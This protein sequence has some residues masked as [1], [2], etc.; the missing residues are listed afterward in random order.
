[1]SEFEYLRYV[2]FGQYLPT[3]STI[4]RLDA[5]TRILCALI[6]L[7]TV[8]L[9]KQLGGIALGLVLVVVG[10]L[11]ARIPLNYA[12]RALLPPM[13][14]LAILTV[15]QVF[16]YSY[17][18]PAYVLFHYGPLFISPAGLSAGATLFIRFI[19]LIL[20]ISLFSFSIS[21]SELI[22]G[23]DGLLSPFSRIGLPT[24]D[25]VMMIE[26]AMHFLPFLTQAAE[27]IAKAQASRG[28]DWGVRRKGI[29]QSVR[30]VLPLIVPLFLI[31][32]KRAE[33]LALAMEARGYGV[34]VRRTSMVILKF[35][36]NDA[37]AIVVTVI[38]STIIFV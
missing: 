34:N 11:V 4:H 23:L 3:G 7:A 31:S 21:T 33:N 9:T 15:F 13:P 26:V 38:F 35:T 10:L 5:R 19:C 1:M 20:G 30:Q 14:F 18:N 2:N 6:F 37:L 36:S 8:T 22:N 16:F 24:H 12:L 28:A 32:L 17:L 27:R 29:F 25:F